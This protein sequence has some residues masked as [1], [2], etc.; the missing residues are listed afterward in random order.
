M[1]KLVDESGYKLK[2]DNDGMTFEV[3]VS[4]YGDSGKTYNGIAEFVQHWILQ[5]EHFRPQHLKDPKHLA[6]IDRDIAGYKELLGTGD[7]NV[8]MFIKMKQE[9][10]NRHPDNLAIVNAM[11]ATGCW[12]PVK[13]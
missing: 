2:A 1:Q 9:T 3:E 11:K 4:P 7:A 5:L 8:R 13:S 10:R 6:W 12:K